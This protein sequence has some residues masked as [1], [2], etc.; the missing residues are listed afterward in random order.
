MRGKAQPGICEEALGFAVDFD[1]KGDSVRKFPALREHLWD[2]ELL[3]GNPELRAMLYVAVDL[4]DALEGRA[5]SPR[6]PRASSKNN[7][8]T[9]P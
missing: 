4:W 2:G 3:H 8:L 6:A 5:A 7:F 1:R 9:S